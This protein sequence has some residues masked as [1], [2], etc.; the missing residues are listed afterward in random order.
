MA[1]L[2]QP[3]PAQEPAPSQWQVPLQDAVTG[4]ATTWHSPPT[5]AAERHAPGGAGQSLAT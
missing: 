5:Q 3:G 4:A 2:T 1:S